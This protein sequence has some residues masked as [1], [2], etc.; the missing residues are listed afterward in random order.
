[1]MLPTASQN[2]ALKNKLRN[3][4]YSTESDCVE[5]RS[6]D[7]ENESDTC[8]MTDEELLNYRLKLQEDETNKVLELLKKGEPVLIE[9]GA[10]FL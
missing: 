9:D 6:L 2:L 5:L 3:S 1:M 4:P 10:D 7:D 8:D